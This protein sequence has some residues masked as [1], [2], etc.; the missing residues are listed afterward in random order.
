MA[1]TLVVLAGWCALSVLLAAAHYVWRPFARAS[2]LLMVLH[3]TLDP[4]V[5]D[6]H[7]FETEGSDVSDFF[8]SYAR[9]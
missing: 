7:E 5:S 4:F 3:P 6:P 2:G 1:T 9:P 8:R